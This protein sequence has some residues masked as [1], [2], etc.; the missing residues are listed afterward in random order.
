[1]LSYDKQLKALSQH[2]RKNMTDAENMLWL[3]LRRKQL[4]GRPFY[5]QKIIGK[6]IVD[7]YCP[8]AN[9]VIE[10]DGGQHYSEIGKAKDRAR[11]DVLAKMG[12]KVLRFSDRDVFENIGGVMEEIWSCL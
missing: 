9:L 3:K 2:L 1:M 11:D 10:L 5:R 7:F 6:Y 4:K 8:K 12:I